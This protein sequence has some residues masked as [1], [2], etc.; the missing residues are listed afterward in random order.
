MKNFKSLDSGILQSEKAYEQQPTM[1]NTDVQNKEKESET[2]V[3]LA[4]SEKKNSSK[5]T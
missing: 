1:L 2:E 5:N 3:Y 4:A